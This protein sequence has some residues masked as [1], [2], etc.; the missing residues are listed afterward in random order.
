MDN[1]IWIAGVAFWFGL[2]LLMLFHFLVRV[3]SRL[4]INLAGRL[5]ALGTIVVGLS[6]VFSYAMFSGYI[7]R[8]LG[9]S[10]IAAQGF[11]FGMVLYIVIAW[12]Y[13]R[14]LNAKRSA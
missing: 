8:T 1:R 12:A 11:I 10:D 4:K 13:T 6:G 2:S 14:F 7:E 3:S 9:I 5:L